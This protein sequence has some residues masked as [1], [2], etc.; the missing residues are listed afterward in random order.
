MKNIIYMAVAV[1]LL[2]ACAGGRYDVAQDKDVQTSCFEV[3]HEMKKLSRKNS[4]KAMA[5]HE[6]LKK[7]HK[8]KNCG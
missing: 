1:T 5:R 2:T 6:A 3:E 7:L 4:K 8:K